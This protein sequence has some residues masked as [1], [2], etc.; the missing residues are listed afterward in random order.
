MDGEG[1]AHGCFMACFD[2]IPEDI[3][4]M[5]VV[6]PYRSNRNIWYPIPKQP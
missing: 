6:F 2:P 3:V 4:S 5:T 1:A